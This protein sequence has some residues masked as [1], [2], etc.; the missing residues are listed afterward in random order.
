MKFETIL[1]RQFELYGKIVIA[2]IV[3]SCIRFMITGNFGETTFTYYTIIY[4]SLGYV[5]MGSIFK[6]YF[7]V[8]FG[9]DLTFFD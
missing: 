2:V 5:F 3:A 9:R 6:Y 7:P 4:L 1:N 8:T